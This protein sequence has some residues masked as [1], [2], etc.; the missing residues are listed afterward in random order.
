M[1]R[2]MFYLQV[3]PD[4]EC[5]Y[6]MDLIPGIS[7]KSHQAG[8]NGYS[9]IDSY[10]DAMYYDLGVTLCCVTEIV[11]Q[12]QHMQLLNCGLFP[13]G[14]YRFDVIVFSEFRNHDMNNNV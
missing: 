13:I 6:R 8:L 3:K 4:S 10:I 11:L 12:A 14:P 1:C 7:L 5:E 9:N 2:Y